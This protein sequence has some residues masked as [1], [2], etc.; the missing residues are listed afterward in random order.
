[1]KVVFFAGIHQVEFPR[2]IRN[3]ERFL[4]K[5]HI[6]NDRARISEI[7]TPYAASLGG[8]ELSYLTKGGA[9]ALIYKVTNIDINRDRVESRLH[10]LLIE[11]MLSIR[12]L[13]LSLWL[14][15]DNAAEFDRGWI[16]TESRVNN[17]TWASRYSK[18]NGSF[19]IVSFNQQEFSL[20]RKPPVR[21]AERYIGSSDSPTLLRGDRLRYQRFMYFISSTRSSADVAMKIADYC[22]ALESLVSTAHTELSHQVSERVA[23]TLAPPGSERIA[24]FKLI[25]EAYGYR[26]KAVHGAHFK[27]KDFA[28]LR[29]CSIGIDHVCRLLHH[30]Y[31]DPETG[32]ADAID[33]SD[34]VTSEYFVYKT[35]GSP[36]KRNAE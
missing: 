7:V 21:A 33:S 25:K 30:A 10:E 24:I 1:M 3:G 18:A 28:R 32:L 29:D 11:D 6:T 15:K 27:I 5:Y 35:L 9:K 12:L 31:F 23:A 13:Q 4:D 17:N 26:S 19:D 8:V 2:S 36:I 20:A 34:E 14:L 16:C 22:S